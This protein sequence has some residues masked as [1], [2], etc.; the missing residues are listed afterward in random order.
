[1]DRVTARV[2]CLPSST[3]V[4][5]E[6]ERLGVAPM[7]LEG[8]LGGFAAEMVKLTGLS[9]ETVAAFQAMISPPA[10][11]AV[12]YGDAGSISILLGGAVP[13]LL[14]A[15]SRLEHGGR[16]SEMAA[17]AALRTT[18]ERYHGR[19]LGATRAGRLTMEW[20]T[21]TYVMGIIN[22][23]PDSFSGDGLGPNVDAAVAQ[24]LRFI[25]DGADILDVGGESTRP[26][27][28]T[29]SDEEEI[30]RVV[31]VIEQLARVVAAPISVDSYKVEVVRRAL[32]AGATI[33]ND[34][35][36]LQHDP[37]LAN[38]AAERDVPIILMHNR[39]ALASRTDLGGHFRQVEYYDLVGEVVDG[40]R[41]SVELALERGVKW[42]NIIVD[43]GIGFGKTPQHNLV[44][45]RRLKELRSLGRPILMGTS[46]KSVIGLTLDVPPGDRVEGTGA[47]VAVSIANGADIVRVHDVKEMAR[48]SRMTDAIVRPVMSD[49]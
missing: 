1:M 19:R 33:V 6:A 36:G 20:G 44:V 37:A 47:T 48:V 9:P 41:E 25:E 17:G 38:L 2:L 23:T 16:E 12:A 7:V 14:D 4:R 22:V 31:P 8:F 13:L 42:E 39:R 49:E 10:G 15:A 35:W 27:S 45:M 28:E 29:V 21:R 46:R 30:A 43:P 40:L 3:D 18:L 11:L 26:G 32:D 24:A 34:I 5:E